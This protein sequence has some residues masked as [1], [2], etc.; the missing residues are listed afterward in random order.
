MP[1]RIQLKR[2]KGWRKPEGAV[3]VSRPTRW[4]NPFRVGA[5]L[6]FPFSEVFGTVVRDQA[7]AVE[8]F[9]IYARITSGYGLL[10]QRELQGKDLAC[11]CKP[12]DP[13]H[14]DVLLEVANA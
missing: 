3:V 9:A 13:C 2:T 1:E 14:A 8:I 5:E 4:G 11:W 12:A 10:A 7:H 6:D